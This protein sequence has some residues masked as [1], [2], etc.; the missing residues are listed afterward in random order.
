MSRQNIAYKRFVEEI[1]RCELCG[2]KRN[3]ELHHII[4]LVCENEG[5]DLDTEDNWICVCGSCH[6]K[7]T[8]KG[9]LTKIGLHK[10][11]YLGNVRYVFYKK[12][13]DFI[14]AE[15]Q[16]HVEDVFAIFNEVF[17]L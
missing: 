2:S 1:G 5:V 4:P 8:P 10:N 16:L 12:C 17:D 11:T 14:K 15:K 9:L 13:D 3:L 6:A 7:L